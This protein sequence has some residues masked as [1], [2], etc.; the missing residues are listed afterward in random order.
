[1]DHPQTCVGC[2]KPRVDST[3]GVCGEGVCRKCRIFLSDE[4]FPFVP[5]RP[6]ELRHTYYC[7]S[8]YDRIVE[9]FRAEYEASLERAKEVNVLYKESKSTVRV[10]SKAKEP[11][12]VTGARDRDDAIM[13]L[14]FQAAR[15]GYDTLIEVE[16]SSQK[17]RNAGWQTSSWSGQGIPAEIRSASVP[18]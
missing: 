11:V 2:R 17:I 18:G 14:A 6:A 4:E 7:G 10:S 5:E 3:C 16:V 9:P 15:A 1:M 12:R 13:R 8:C